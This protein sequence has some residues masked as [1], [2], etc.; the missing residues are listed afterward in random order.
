MRTA[1]PLVTCSS[2]IEWRPDAT[3]PAIS[4]PSVLGSG[5]HQQ[6]LGSR[7]RQAFLGD[8]VV[9]GVLMHR[10]QQTALLALVLQAERH[11]DVRALDGHVGVGLD[12]DGRQ[13]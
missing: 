6:V 7:S 8:L 10:R 9:R 1:T 12:D 2:M 13:C 4:M 11:D 3:G 5:V